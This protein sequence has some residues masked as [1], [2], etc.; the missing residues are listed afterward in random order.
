MLSASLLFVT[1]Y[2]T[3]KSRVCQA[4][5]PYEPQNR[6]NVQKAKTSFGYTADTKRGARLRRVPLCGI[7]EII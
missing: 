7:G 2:Y 1:L 4:K 3:K 6:H 5:T